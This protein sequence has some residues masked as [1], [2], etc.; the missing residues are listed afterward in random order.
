MNKDQLLLIAFFGSL[1]GFIEAT[2]GGVL[3]LSGAPMSGTILA[4]IGFSILC[5]ARGRGLKASSLAYVALLAASFK[6]LD[7]PLFSLPIFY[8]HIINPAIAIASQGVAFALVFGATKQF[9]SPQTI[10]RLFAA[11]GLSALAF[12]LASL[13]IFGWQTAHTLSPLNAILVDLPLI[14]ILSFVIFKS[15]KALFSTANLAPKFQAACTVAFSVFAII[16]RIS[17]H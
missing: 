1:W 13:G 15:V 3:H 17:L 14:T 9:S 2:L 16:A 7:A 8:N 5:I 4:S 6:F 10:A 12:N 11:A